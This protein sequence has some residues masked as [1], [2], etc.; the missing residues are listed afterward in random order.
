MAYVTSDIR[1]LRKKNYYE[2]NQT[3]NTNLLKT[4]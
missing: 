1:A 2:K 4:K 3:E